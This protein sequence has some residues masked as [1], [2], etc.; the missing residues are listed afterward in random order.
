MKIIEFNVGITKIMKI[1]EFHVNQENH[2][3]LKS[4]Q[5]IYENHEII[6]FQP[7]ITKIMKIKEFQ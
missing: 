2:E 7:I 4:A 6:E 3:N 1:F 5:D